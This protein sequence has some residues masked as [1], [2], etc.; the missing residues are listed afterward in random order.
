MKQVRREGGREGGREEM[1]K[2]EKVGEKSHLH[3]QK[4][5]KLP[6]LSKEKQI[7]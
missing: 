3:E 7:L 4:L 1:K 6:P 2:E 5:N